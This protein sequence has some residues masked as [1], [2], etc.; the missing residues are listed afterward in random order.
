MLYGELGLL[1]LRCTIEGRM[2]SYWGKLIVNNTDRMSNIMYNAILSDATANNMP[3]KWIDGIKNIL[4]SSG[5]HYMW[6]MQ[7]IM[8]NFKPNTIKQRLND[9]HIQQCIA[10]CNESNKGRN[11]VALKYTW[12]QEKYFSTLQQ[13]DIITLFKFR[14][15]NHRLP[16]ET[17]RYHNIEYKDR[18]CPICMNDLGDEYHYHF[19]CP[20]FTPARKSHLQKFCNYKHSNMI[21]YTQ[22]MNSRNI[23]EM[24]SLSRFARI[25][26]KEIRTW[27][28]TLSTFRN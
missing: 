3:Y 21:I 7:S 17:G 26:M 22:L 25:K 10:H 28:H 24:K 4:N 5:N 23:E 18:T 1:P 19:K 13:A 11:Y 6:P 20:K 15:S 8:H 27:S 12:K 14:T 2:I 16:I 9:I